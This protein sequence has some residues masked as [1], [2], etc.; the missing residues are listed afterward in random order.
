MDTFYL[1]KMA[2]VNRL[3]QCVQFLKK[4]CPFL[5]PEKKWLLGNCLLRKFSS[6]CVCLPIPTTLKVNKCGMCKQNASINNARTTL[7]VCMHIVLKQCSSPSI[8]LCALK[9]AL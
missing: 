9:K 2:L 6:V 1:S 5:M 7:Q 4:R 8:N 3:F